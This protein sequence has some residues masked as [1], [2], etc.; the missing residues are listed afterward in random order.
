M[1]EIIEH[2]PLKRALDVVLTSREFGAEEALQMGLLSRVVPAAGV[3]QAVED[4]VGTLRDRDREVIR[5]CKRYIRAAGKMPADARSAFALVE[6][7][8]FAMSKH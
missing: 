2:L 8:Q 1:E 6:Q 3:P 4:F 7:T 5:A